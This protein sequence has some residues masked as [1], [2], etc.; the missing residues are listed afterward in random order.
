MKIKPNIEINP[1]EEGLIEELF[2]QK[3]KIKPSASLNESLMKM[4]RNAEIGFVEKCETQTI[5]VERKAKRLEVWLISGS[6]VALI[7][8]AAG[9][10]NYFGVTINVFEGVVD[11][12]GLLFA[13]AKDDVSLIKSNS[14]SPMWILVA[15]IGLSLAIMQLLLTRKLDDK[16]IENLG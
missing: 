8:L 5:I 11:S 9:L 15:I 3:T 1:I 13:T 7:A 6:V 4:A 12:F 2:N 10:M 16:E 14:V